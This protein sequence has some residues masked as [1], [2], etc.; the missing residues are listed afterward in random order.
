MANKVWTEDEV[1]ALIQ[2]MDKKALIRPL[3][4][5]W[6]RQTTDEQSTHDTH[7]TNKRGFNKMDAPF[8][9]SLIES[10]GKCKNFTD[11]QAAAIRKM[12][13][14]YRKQL[15]EIANEN[16][17]NTPESTAQVEA[18]PETKE[19]KPQ[20]EQTTFS[21]KGGVVEVVKVGNNGK[22]TVLGSTDNKAKM[23]MNSL[24]QVRQRYM[25][26]GEDANGAQGNTTI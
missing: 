26:R 19:M 16:N 20:K 2:R 25:R 14:K 1:V 18:T 13:T 17:G 23:D 8:S 22:Q 15:T 11:K 21:W 3:N 10:F 9:G 24:D 4:K 6:D 7:I 12:L 5:M